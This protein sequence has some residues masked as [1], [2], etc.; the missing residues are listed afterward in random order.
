MVR[1]SFHIQPHLIIVA[2]TCQ[3]A[4]FYEVD[5]NTGEYLDMKSP[6]IEYITA[7]CCPTCRGPITSPRYGR[8]TKR[9]ILD[10]VERN[11]ASTFSK[12][13]SGAAQALGELEDQIEHM[14]TAAAALPGPSTTLTDKEFTKIVGERRTRARRINTPLSPNLIT[15]EVSHHGFTKEENT[16]WKVLLRAVTRS[17][18]RLF[19]SAIKKSPHVGTYEAA[20][21]TLY[22][23]E[24]QNILESDRVSDAPE[25]LAMVQADKKMGQPP[26]KAD[27]R[28]QVD[29]YLLSVTFRLYVVQI[30]RSRY[31]TLTSGT[32][33]PGDGKI[34]SPDRIWSEFMDFILESCEADLDDARAIALK[35]SASRQIARCD[36]SK[37]RV[38]VERFKLS[39]IVSRLDS[40]RLG[41]FSAEARQRLVDAIQQ[42]STNAMDLLYIAETNYFR[43]RPS[44]NIEDIR[45]DR[46]WFEENC[47]RQ[48]RL[49]EEEYENFKEYIAVDRP[50]QPLSAREKDDIV[51]AM[52]FGACFSGCTLHVC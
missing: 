47:T 24:L 51:K 33:V 19:D 45:L 37:L 25:L 34:V 48:G 35:S 30:A 4:G 52:G 44:K 1:P 50:Y 36:I 5:P 39:I 26:H 27:T 32:P 12:T 40:S 49:I 8:V 6:S 41:V 43:S 20:L 38:S 21:T 14:K 28:F 23:Q 31:D 18:K 46:L 29:A 16:G 13:L 42:A 9:A 11:V 7:P 2:G 15:G 10:V 3:M 17:Y 22:R